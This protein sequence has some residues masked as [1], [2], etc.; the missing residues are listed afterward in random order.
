MHTFQD[1]QLEQA[2]VSLSRLLKA[3]SYYPEAHPAVNKAAEEATQKLRGYIARN[4]KEVITL[5]LK[6][7]G[8]LQDEKWLNPTNQVLAQLAQRLFQHKIKSLAIFDD[9]QEQHLLT[10]IHCLAQDPHQLESKGGAARTLEQAQVASIFL[11]QIDLNAIS[12]T[13]RKHLS[14]G[15]LQ[16]E[17][18]STRLSRGSNGF[19]SGEHVAKTD[20]MKQNKALAQLLLDAQ[21]MIKL[22]SE[23]Q[24]SEFKGCLDNIHQRLNAILAT[25]QHHSGALQAVA[26]LDNWRD[27][28]T[29]PASYIAACTQCLRQLDPDKLVAM[30]ID[31]VGK[32]S[33]WRA[34]ALRT[35]KLLGP[36]AYPIVWEKLIVE[37]SPKAR[38][39][40]TTVMT[41]FDPAADR[42]MLEHLEDSRWYVVRNALNILSS[43]RNPEYIEAFKAQLLHSDTRVAK[44]ALTALAAIRHDNA[45]DVLLEYLS[46]P[47][48]PL[49]E[50]AILALGAQQDLH[51]I[52]LLSRIALQSDPLLQQKKI[53]LKAIEA[54]GE[55][56]SRDANPALIAVIKKWKIIKRREYKE[57]RLAAISALG[58]TAGKQELKLLQRMSTSHDANVAQG[59]KLALQS[60]QKE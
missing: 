21:R 39:F 38:R 60:G 10:L 34:L 1:P 4:S 3:A 23:E 8:F 37:S 16:G 19:G 45:T 51:A 50:L 28:T 30:F 13:R 26:T 33:Q 5:T 29:Y 22:G 43:R 58:K 31:T 42:I 57:L 2:L 40:L 12:S 7:Q 25:P 27:T 20:R 44:E 52:P 24:L 11:N 48:C 46:M 59:A 18:D 35:I 17:E 56:R 6:R 49:P 9:L 53:R 55:I 32:E 47:K 15:P 54:L 36:D 41:A 14:E